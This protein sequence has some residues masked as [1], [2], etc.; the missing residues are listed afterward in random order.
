MGRILVVDDEKDIL[1]LLQEALGACG[2]EVTGALSG[3]EAL[4][5]L[6]QEQVDLVILD[7]RMP[8]MTGIELLERIRKSHARLPVI[9][10]S[11]YPWLA[12]GYV[13]WSSEVAAV[14]PKPLDL[15]HL[16][17]VVAKTLDEGR[18]QAEATS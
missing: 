1:L 18:A 3:V 14:I 6:D 11:A 12:R 17:L 15:E 5:F 9:I 8:D 10:C 2:H 13:V 16:A 4:D 7:I